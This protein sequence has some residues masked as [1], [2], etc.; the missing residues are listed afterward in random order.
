MKLREYCERLIF[1]DPVGHGR[2]G[3]ELLWRK[4]YYDVVTTAKR[5]RKVWEK[6]FNVFVP[7]HYIFKCDV[8]S[9]VMFFQNNSRYDIFTV[10]IKYK[11]QD[12]NSGVKQI[13][14]GTVA[15]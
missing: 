1:S 6:K 8:I 13:R 15:M 5:L 2:K 10:E 14:E 12:R 7:V 4:G 9:F 3:E 11:C